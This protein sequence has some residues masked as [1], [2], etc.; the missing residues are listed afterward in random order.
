MKKINVGLI[1]V[2]AFISL[3]SCKPDD[4]NFELPPP[5]DAAEVYAEDLL[6]LNTF[7]DT[8]FYNAEDFPAGSTTD[9]DIVFTKFD[10][11]N[12]DHVGKP[13]LST[14]VQ[15]I[16]INRNNID[17]KIY[18]LLARQGDGAKNVTRLDSTLLTYKGMLSDLTVFD[19]AEQPVW[20]PQTQNITGFR[21]GMEP[22]KEAA[23]GVTVNGDGTFSFEGSGI[24][25]IFFPSGLG[26]FNQTRTG[27]PAY[28]PLIFTF[29]VH[30]VEIADDDRDGVDNIFEDLDGDGEVD[31]L[32]GDDTDR[33]GIKNY[34]DTDD[35]NDG[36]PTLTE[37]TV[38]DADGN[39]VRDA[40][41]KRVLDRLK[42]SDNDGIPDYLDN[43]TRT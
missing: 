10:A 25:A 28:S 8:H 43:Q 34:L 15:E 13:K 14:Q 38:F 16:T 3:I 17:Y 33:D 19:S 35:D 36:I 1:M 31:T 7:L 27:I 30:K 39:I 4:N 26:Y 12:P 42:D 21:V 9:R 6:E 37:I 11:T 2:L 18:Y 40:N 22:F 20:L 23:S 24:G 41:G 32:N 29:K 5:R